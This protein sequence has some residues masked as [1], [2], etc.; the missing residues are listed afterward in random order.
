VSITDELDRKIK[1]SQAVMEQLERNQP[2]SSVLSQVRLL[3]TMTDDKVRVALIDILTHGLTNVP[4]QGK[5]FT[6]EAYKK[7]VILHIKLCSVE[8]VSKL[9]I[10]EIVSDPWRERIPVKDHA[11]TLSVYEMENY[12]PPPAISPGDNQETANLK[13][14][15]GAFHDGVKSILVTLRAWIYDYVSRIWLTL[16]R[17]KD[18]IALLSADYRL[19]TD[20]LDALQTPV[21]SELLASVDNLSSNNPGNWKLSALGCRNVV[22]KLGTL[23]WNVP[24]QTY[25]TKNGKTLGVSN[26]K[27]KNKLFAYIDVFSKQAPADKQAMLREARELVDSVYNR[28]SKGK[29]QIHHGEAQALVV[30]TFHLVDL[31]NEASELKCIDAL[32]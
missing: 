15:L 7:A 6:D 20:K 27:E 30:D 22:I 31:L 13:L 1:V 26:K 18:R 28:G 9:D 16:L 29:K 11:V 23:L 25:E 32:P 17:E 2:L 10:N 21:G 12:S 4:Y 14:Q 19:I 24:G 3:A 8:D 5:P